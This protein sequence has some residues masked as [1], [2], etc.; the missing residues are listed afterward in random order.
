MIYGPKSNEYRLRLQMSP[1][2]DAPRRSIW[3]VVF[4]WLV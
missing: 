2:L 1:R 3:R 4:G